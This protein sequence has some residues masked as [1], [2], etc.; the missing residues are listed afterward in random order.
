MAVGIV[1]SSGERLAGA[2]SITGRSIAVSTD[3]PR[4]AIVCGLSYDRHHDWPASDEFLSRAPEAVGSDS[5]VN[6]SAHA[7]RVADQRGRRCDL[8]PAPPDSQGIRV[9]EP[10]G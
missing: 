5:G 1:N 10:G 6:D 3:G 4:G 2:G 7:R 8:P 9:S